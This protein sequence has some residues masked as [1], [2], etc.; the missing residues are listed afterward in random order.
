M[1]YVLAILAALCFTASA[2]DPL[3]D[4]LKK[5]AKA[6]A[7]ALKKDRKETER[8]KKLY[9]IQDTPGYRIIGISAPYYI[10]DGKP[11]PCDQVEFRCE[12]GKCVMVRTGK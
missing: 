4:L 5:H 10:I 8:R 1:K 6:E 3:T 11:V 9:G 2:G 7:E 12:N